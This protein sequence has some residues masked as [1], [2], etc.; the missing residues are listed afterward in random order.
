M[1]FISI[2]K[3]LSR[4]VNRILLAVLIVVSSAVLISTLV[5]MT[6]KL[7]EI[8]KDRKKDIIERGNIIIKNSAMALKG[9]A[10]E[11]SFVSIKELVNSARNADKDLLYG[12]FM[13]KDRRAWVISRRS[14][15][16][17]IINANT[18]D[19]LNDSL[20]IW[21]DTVKKMSYREMNLK[22]RDIIEFASPVKSSGLRLGTIRYGVSLLPMKKQITEEKRE[23]VRNMIWIIVIIS[24]SILVIYFISY[25]KVKKEADNITKPLLKLTKASEII[26]SGDYDAEVDIASND[27]VGKL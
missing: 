8:E 18:S 13:D 7:K 5:N 15:S 25:R 20:S 11:N 16:L 22:G 19:I 27:E 10:E 26:T 24:V 6:I 23:F 21:A 17:E 12:I 9:M 3:K 4:I 1:A 2:R 14:D